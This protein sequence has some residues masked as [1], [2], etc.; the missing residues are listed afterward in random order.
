VPRYADDGSGAAG[1]AEHDRLPPT[2][3]PS[4]RQFGKE[5]QNSVASCLPTARHITKAQM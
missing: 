5:T 3:D 1:E 4:I 2:L